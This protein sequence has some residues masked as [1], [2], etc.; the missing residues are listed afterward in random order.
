[1]ARGSQMSLREYGFTRRDIRGG[2]GAGTEVANEHFHELVGSVELYIY[3]HPS[4]RIKGYE[5][6]KSSLESS[7]CEVVHL[8][9]GS[10]PVGRSYETIRVTNKGVEIPIPLLRQAHSWAHQRNLLHMFYK[11]G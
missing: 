9:G 6:L 10:S 7:G 8:E 1:M 2:G 5:A 3:R 11:K 4:R